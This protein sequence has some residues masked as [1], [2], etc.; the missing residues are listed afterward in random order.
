MSNVLS[1]VAQAITV[2]TAPA[3]PDAPTN[4]KD[5]T[6]ASPEVAKA[7]AVA[8]GAEDSSNAKWVLAASKLWSA[9]ARAEHLS[10]SADRSDNSVYSKIRTMVINAQKANIVT[11]LT[12]SSTIGFTDQERADRR[13]YKNRVDNVHMKRVKEHLAKIE[14]VERDGANVK[15][16]MGERGAEMCSEWIEKIQKAKPEKIDFDATEVIKMLRDLKAE[17]LS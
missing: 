4:Y 10:D 5:L 1:Q 17:F 14:S 2:T 11:L 7:V 15:K 13:Y 6:L 8:V 3:L 12:A 16:T 9:G